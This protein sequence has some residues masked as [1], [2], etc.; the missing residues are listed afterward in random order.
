MWPSPGNA[1]VAFWAVCAAA[2]R[3]DL[4]KPRTQADTGVV[5][6]QQ[7]QSLVDQHRASHHMHTFSWKASFASTA[8][9]GPGQCDV[10]CE[11]LSRQVQRL[12][13][14]R[15]RVQNE[16]MC[17][18]SLGAAWIVWCAVKCDTAVEVAAG[19]LLNSGI[20]LALCLQGTV[21]HVVPSLRSR[22]VAC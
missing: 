9:I 16:S 8:K 21:A 12:F 18:S 7:P 3:S 4:C 1:D 19:V 17:I 14:A 15:H 20:L 6:T 22:R 5:P 11:E 10:V 2:L 13:H